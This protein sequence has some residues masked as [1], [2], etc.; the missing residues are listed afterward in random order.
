MN[1]ENPRVTSEFVVVHDG[2]SVAVR[3]DHGIAGWG[4]MLKALHDPVAIDEIY[5]GRI[6]GYRETIDEAHQAGTVAAIQ[7]ISQLR[8]QS[9]EDLRFVL[10]A[11][12]FQQA[13]GQ[14]AFDSVVEVV[15][16]M[17][18]VTDR[19]FV[20]IRRADFRS[21]DEALATAKDALG[22]VDGLT[23]QGKFIR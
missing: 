16:G 8:G 12:A 11:R 4:I 3:L 23:D 17:G 5:L 10:R 6:I 2:V 20:P 14:G 7:A 15:S 1:V 22:F 13:G 18:E 21:A 9:T 19:M